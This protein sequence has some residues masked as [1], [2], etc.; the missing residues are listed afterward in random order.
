MG[1]AAAETTIRSL[2]AERNSLRAEREALL[3]K[4]GERDQEIAENR[5]YIGQHI[6]TIKG[7]ENRLDHE[8]GNVK[9][10]TATAARDALDIVKLEDERD[11]LRS[12]LASE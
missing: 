5:R 4:L 1:D 9:A 11:T 3:L 8:L 12:R 2:Y 10:L 7:L 6:E